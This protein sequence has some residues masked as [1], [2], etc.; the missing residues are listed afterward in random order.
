MEIF[1]EGILTIDDH[2]MTT[3]GI[4]QIL[5]E[6]GFGNVYTAQNSE[7]ALKILKKEKSN[8]KLIL[9]DINHNKG[10]NGVEFV[11]EISSSHGYP[12]GIV[13]LTCMEKE[14]FLPN[15]GGYEEFVNSLNPFTVMEVGYIRKMIVD[16]KLLPEVCRKSLRAVHK[17]SLRL[18]RLMDNEYMALSLDEGRYKLVGMTYDQQMEVFDV[19]GSQHLL[20]F[21]YGFE[22]TRIGNAIQELEY[23]INKEN[24]KEVE[25]QNFFET[26]PKFLQD[27]SYK[28]VHPHIVLKCNQKIR[29]I[30][31][32][33]LEPFDKNNLS[34]IL[35]L[36]LPCK[37]IYTTGRYP[38]I[39]AHVRS[40]QAQLQA[41][42]S[43]FED[44]VNR[45][46]IRQEYGLTLYDPKM[47]VVIGRRSNLDPVLIKRLGKDI[48]NLSIRN[49]DEI[50]ARMK[51]KIC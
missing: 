39:S 3:R 8:I 31:D 45:I 44:D 42:R 16:E 12:L 7:S 48:P 27:D 21:I 4:K 23:L 15:Y 36:K 28:K 34:D 43:F 17:E 13:F 25:L 6:K 20:S 30:P 32:F 40:A 50:I 49:Y 19:K 2:E 35:E 9:T 46:R 18:K 29:H 38:K 10:T 51:R 5:N 37:R 11:K 33:I 22:S 14:Y 26:N 47:I 24:V 41:Y 1:N